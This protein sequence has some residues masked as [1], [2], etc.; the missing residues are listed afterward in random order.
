MNKVARFL[1]VFVFAISVSLFP[2]NNASAQVGLYVA[3][4]GGYT[5]GPDASWDDEDYDFNSD[6]DIQETGVFGVKFGYTPYVLRFF[7]FEFEYSYLNPDVDKTELASA[8]SDY[9]DIEGDVKFHNF[10]FNAIV[11][12]PK[13]RIHPYAGAGLG[14]SYVDVSSTL[15]SRLGGVN[16]SENYSADDTVFAWQILAGVEIDLTTNFSLDIGYRYFATESEHDDYDDHDYDHDYD[17]DHDHD[18]DHD[19]TLDFNTSMITLG[20]KYRF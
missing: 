20:L 3:V 16:Y 10:M 14:A 13:G 5:F 1:G 8:G 7:S 11:K 12:Y 15:T 2:F 17:H 4:F 18:Y 9:T 6:L 19:K